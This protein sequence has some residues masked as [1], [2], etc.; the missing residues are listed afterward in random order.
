MRISRRGTV[1]R[2]AHV[3]IEKTYM[4]TKKPQDSGF[5]R[6]E[7]LELPVISLS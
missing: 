6:G 4:H 5:K 1:W 2:G 3:A 7:V